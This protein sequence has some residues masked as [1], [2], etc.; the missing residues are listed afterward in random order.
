[1]LKKIILFKKTDCPICFERVQITNYEKL[2]CNHIY[3]K[4]CINKCIK[5]D[6]H[7]CA[8]CRSDFVE[9]TMTMER[10]T[11]YCEYIVEL[12]ESL[13]I[14]KLI[15]FYE[16]NNIQCLT[17]DVFVKDRIKEIKNEYHK[18]VNEFYSK[19]D[20][21]T[22]KI[23]QFNNKIKKMFENATVFCDLTKYN[24]GCEVDIRVCD[25]FL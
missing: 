14:P 16:I 13:Y 12:I 4:T 11:K 23:I 25:F 21:D 7:K 22:I 19:G 8:L 2:K 5:T 15:E 3:C 6:N 9:Y 1:M 20:F 24:I 18:V 17:L 10:I